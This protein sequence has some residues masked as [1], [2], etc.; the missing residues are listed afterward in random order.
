M[1]RIVVPHEPAGKS[2]QNVV[3]LRG[4]LGFDRAIRRKSG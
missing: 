4:G 3:D 1:M 2:H